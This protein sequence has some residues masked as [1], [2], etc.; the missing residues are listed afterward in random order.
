MFNTAYVPSTPLPFYATQL[1]S[2]FLNS[3]ISANHYKVKKIQQ[4]GNPYKGDCISNV[5]S[6]L[7]FL[8]NSEGKENVMTINVTVNT[9][10]NCR[11]NP[12]TNLISH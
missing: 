8:I 5:K 6:L 1:I 4:M 3:L 9:V 10:N 12:K 7:E 11:D 2:S